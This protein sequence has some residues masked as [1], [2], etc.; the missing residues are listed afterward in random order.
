M[1][2]S[3]HSSPLRP[4]SP[5][6]HELSTPRRRRR[7]S[8]KAKPVGGP[9]AFAGNAGERNTAEGENSTRLSLRRLK[10]GESH[11]KIRHGASELLRLSE[12]F[13]GY[14]GQSEGGGFHFAADQALPSDS[15]LHHMAHL[16]HNIANDIV[17]IFALRNEDRATNRRRHSQ[18][19][20][21]ANATAISRK[22]DKGGSEVG[23]LYCHK[24]RRTDTPQWR[25]GPDGPMTLCNVCGLMYAKRRQNQDD[26]TMSVSS[27][28]NRHL[29]AD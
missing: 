4:T 25:L 13:P 10:Q 5:T 16:S 14:H 17:D 24:C 22:G 7:S 3:H 19:A 8:P 12:S 1:A 29:R 18:S 9:G 20:A 28:M 26:L 11:Q 2:S 6:T 21:L 23:E 27:R 15:D